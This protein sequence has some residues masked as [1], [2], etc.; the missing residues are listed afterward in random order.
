[1]LMQTH[2]ELTEADLDRIERLVEC[3]T[4]GPWYSYRVGRDA[5]AVSNCIELGACNELGCFRCMEV[6]GCSAADQDFIASARQDL[7]R[8]LFEVR[9]LRAR[10]EAQREAVVGNRMQSLR[11]TM[12][13]A[14]ATVV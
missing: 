8:L 11:N 3:A 4:A 1:M 5:D 9:V 6:P 13:D 10:L 7:P 12:L 14:A 2:K